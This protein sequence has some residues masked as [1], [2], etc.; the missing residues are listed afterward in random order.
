LA[1]GAG[2]L[3]DEMSSAQ[4]MF[5]GPL[6]SLPAYHSVAVRASP[7]TKARLQ[8]IQQRAPMAQPTAAAAPGAAVGVAQAATSESASMNRASGSSAVA[9]GDRRR[10][11][12]LR[13]S[14][15]G[16]WTP[17]EV[18]GVARRRGAGKRGRVIDGA[19]WRRRRTIV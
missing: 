4:V 18:R 8:M 19:A 1:G 7:R 16:K 13:K 9:G 2:A 12:A 3:L 15:K 14:S 6:P 11:Q 5:T 10:G 17:E